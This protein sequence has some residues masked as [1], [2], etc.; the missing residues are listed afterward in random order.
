VDDAG[1]TLTAGADAAAATVDASVGLLPFGV[2][3]NQAAAANGSA[4][5]TLGS[6]LAASIFSGAS[7]V[8]S[9]TRAT[10]PGAVGSFDETVSSV[11]ADTSDTTD[12]SAGSGLNL[13]TTVQSGVGRQDYGL[14]RSWSSF[15]PSSA[16]DEASSADR[17]I[18]LFRRTV[19]E[20]LDTLFGSD[21]EWAE[22]QST[23][24]HRASPQAESATNAA[25][26]DESRQPSVA[27][28]AVGLALSALWS[29]GEEADREHPAAEP[30]KPW[31]KRR[32]IGI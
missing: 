4:G 1:L 5:N 19:I 30:G 16:A 8:D 11:S 17:E 15:A 21:I 23:G 24:T 20:S 7:A 26:A 13:D 27:M 31:L 28:L 12:L 10:L 29:E 2:T 9:L 32:R 25:V 14:S 6:G 18:A 3:F 22:V